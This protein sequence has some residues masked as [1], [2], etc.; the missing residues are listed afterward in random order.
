MDGMRKWDGQSSVLLSDVRVR[1]I[2]EHE[3]LI[4]DPRTR[5]YSQVLSPF[6]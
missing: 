3:Q 1:V 6:S 4:G 2:L 5:D